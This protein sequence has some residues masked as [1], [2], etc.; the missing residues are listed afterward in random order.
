[1]KSSRAVLGIRRNRKTCGNKQRGFSMIEVLI[2]LVVL[3]VGLL[4]MALLQ[5]TNL[6][7]TKS[8]N[9]RTQAT[10]LATDMLDMI[11]A[12]HSEVATYASIERG[13][14][15]DVVVPQVGCSTDDDLSS[16]ANIARWS[17]EVVE[18]L[19]AEASANVD[20]DAGTN[21]VTVTVTWDDE[22]WRDVGSAER[23]KSVVLESQ[24]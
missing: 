20:Y 5:T 16:T 4:G 9:Q 8:A 24:L 18:A 13:D 22:Y 11:R 14:F 23:E 1:M 7:F 12:N 17:C 19:G 2:A 15:A 6:R 21:E 3:A 10:N